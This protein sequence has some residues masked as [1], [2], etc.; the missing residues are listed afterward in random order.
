MSE[1]RVAGRYA[2]SLLDLS[3][4][5]NLVEPVLADMKQFGS[6]LA[7]NSELEQVLK[8]PIIQ[9]DKKF[10]ILKQ[11][12]EKSFQKL[13]LSF[14][15][16]IVRKKREQF[17]GAIADGFIEQYNKLNNMA[18]A[19]VKSATPLSEA[20]LAEIKKHIESQTGQRITLAATV[21]QNL[22]G[23]IVVQVGDRLYDASVAGKLSK[24][25]N[26]LLNSYISK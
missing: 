1:Y 4:E 21:D 15:E 5:Q 23:G 6:T 3:R 22:I 19:T 13:T 12:F 20:A 9:G 10:A 26:E 2:K 17:L 11:L 24:L 16:I 25:K 18:S 14:L 7:Q 8:S